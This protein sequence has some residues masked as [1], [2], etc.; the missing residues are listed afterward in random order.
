MKSTTN[1]RSTTPLEEVAGDVIEVPVAVPP[2][3][4]PLRCR[5]TERREEEETA[6]DETRGQ[7]DVILKERLVVEANP[8]RRRCRHRRPFRISDE[9]SPSSPTSSSAGPASWSSTEPASRQEK[10]LCRDCV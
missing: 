5:G 9:C 4:L 1:R 6:R 2:L 7:P 8:R 3:P 10:M